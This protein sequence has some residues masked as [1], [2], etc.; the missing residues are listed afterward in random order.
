MTI[1]AMES[2]FE[3]D[4]VYTMFD[5]QL[6]RVVGLDLDMVEQQIESSQGN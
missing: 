2:N 4:R 3:L 6:K 1:N 5:F